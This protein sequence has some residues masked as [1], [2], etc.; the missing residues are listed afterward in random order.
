MADLISSWLAESWSRG[1]I[2][3][4]WLENPVSY[5]HLHPNVVA[6]LQGPKDLSILVMSSLYYNFHQAPTVV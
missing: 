6:G 4:P 2:G 5:A 3:S 1:V